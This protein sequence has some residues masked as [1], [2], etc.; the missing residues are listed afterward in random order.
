MKKTTLFKQQLQWKHPR[1]S[2]LSRLD[3]DPNEDT[4]T[5]KVIEKLISEMLDQCVVEEDFTNV[6]DSEEKLDDNQKADQVN[7]APN[8]SDRRDILGPM[9]DVTPTEDNSV[10]SEVKSKELT[11][12]DSEYDKF[13]NNTTFEEVQKCKADGH[14]SPHSRD[15][16]AEDCARVNSPD[17]SMRNIKT[18]G[19]AEHLPNAVTSKVT[20]LILEEQS[21]DEE[22][23]AEIEGNKSV[24]QC[25]AASE[26]VVENSKVSV[27]FNSSIPCEEA[28]AVLNDDIIGNIVNGEDDIVPSDKSFSSN[29][30]CNTTSKCKFVPMPNSESNMVVEDLVLPSDDTTFSSGDCARSWEETEAI[31]DE[32][33]GVNLLVEFDAELGI[34]SVDSHASSKNEN[35]ASVSGLCES[36]V[37]TTREEVIDESHKASI[38]VPQTTPHC[39]LYFL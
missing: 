5:R 11:D 31:N 26:V 12:I 14:F 29:E 27:V 13:D 10:G 23:Y 4:V 18:G 8:N 6:G 33:D 36:N 39:H 20:D 19:C 9:A 16:Y 30:E 34:I 22:S 37:I 21:Q 24:T 15:E 17:K 38:D 1:T 2:E 7:V 3:S 35:A 25:T 28:T 32:E